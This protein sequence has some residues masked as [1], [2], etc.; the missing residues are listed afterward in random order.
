MKKFVDLKSKIL[1]LRGGEYLI[2][3]DSEN[4]LFYFDD[5]FRLIKLFKLNIKRGRLYDNNIK[6]S[7]N[8]KYLLIAQLSVKM[9]NIFQ[10]EILTVKYMFIIQL[11]KKRY[12]N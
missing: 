4:R 8:S 9:T 6:I 3:F 11:L 5:S 1:Y 12:M 2:V 10:R 7:N